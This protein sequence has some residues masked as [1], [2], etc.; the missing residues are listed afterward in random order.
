MIAAN[1]SVI[2]HG[3]VFKFQFCDDNFST[4]LSFACYFY[5]RNS[6]ILYLTERR[7]SVRNF[8]KGG[9]GGKAGFYPEWGGIRKKILEYQVLREHISCHLK[10]LCK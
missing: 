2:C 6:Y 8:W 3:L 5:H 4:V 10:P 1:H 9:G 7:V